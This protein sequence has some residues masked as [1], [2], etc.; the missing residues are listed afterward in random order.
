M[1]CPYCGKEIPDK[2]VYVEK[3]PPKVKLE[4]V[5]VTDTDIAKILM[6]AEK[7]AVYI[8]LA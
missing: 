6:E 7:A 2:K 5:V 3:W 8:D 1:K 4:D